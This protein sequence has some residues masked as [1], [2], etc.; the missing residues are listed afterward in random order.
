MRPTASPWTDAGV[1]AVEEH[2]RQE[3]RHELDGL[4]ATFG[5]NALYED[6]PWG[7]RHDDIAR[8]FF[9]PAEQ[10]RLFAR[11][12]YGHIPLVTRRVPFRNE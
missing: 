8:R 10:Q 1:R 5:A 2:V 12:Y 4:L 3:N 7:E 9:A 11:I 6:A